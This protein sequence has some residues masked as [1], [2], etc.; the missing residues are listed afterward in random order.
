[1]RSAGAR[2]HVPVF[3]ERELAEFAHVDDDD[4]LVSEGVDLRNEAS[5][6]AFFEST[7]PLWASIHIA[8]GFSMQPIQDA[9][10]ADF[11]HL[12]SLNAATCFLSCRE[13]VTQMRRA[14]GGRIVNVTAQPAVQPAPSMVAYAA[15][16]AAVASITQCLALEVA[17]DEIF[18]NAIVP[19]IMDTPTN[20]LAMPD[21]DR[22]QWSALSDVA[23]T[24]AGLVAPEFKENGKLV[25][26]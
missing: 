8:G 19:S 17:S 15:S 5:A 14:S 24:I 16:K 1:M 25:P 12:M 9:T 10:L 7:G 20:R 23:E 22:S 4:V 21:A 26:V 6:H 13:A 11:E 2:C 18:V 3:D